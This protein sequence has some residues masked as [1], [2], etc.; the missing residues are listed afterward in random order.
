MHIIVKSIIIKEIKVRHIVYMMW[1]GLSL[2]A[3]G[4]SALMPITILKLVTPQSASVCGPPPAATLS[5]R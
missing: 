2:R 4:G 3:A 1:A 5:L